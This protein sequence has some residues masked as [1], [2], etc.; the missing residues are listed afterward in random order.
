MLCVALLSSFRLKP[1]IFGFGFC[2]KNNPFRSFCVQVANAA[3]KNAS[4]VLIYPDFDDDSILTT[5]LYGHVS[6][7]DW[8]VRHD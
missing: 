6:M 3:R 8:F 1:V 4:A 5:Q 2:N 7:S